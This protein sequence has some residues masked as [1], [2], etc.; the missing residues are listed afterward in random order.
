MRQAGEQYLKRVLTSLISKEAIK[1]YIIQIQ[2][3]EFEIKVANNKTE[4]SKL[5]NKFKELCKAYDRI[6]PQKNFDVPSQNLNYYKKLDEGLTNQIEKPFRDYH[7]ITHHQKTRPSDK[8]TPKNEVDD[9]NAN[10][11]SENNVVNKKP[12]VRKVR[13][14]IYRLCLDY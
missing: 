14:F 5:E 12:I 4:K 3:L 1:K 9:P 8:V 2:A 6:K 10:N 11:T 13:L 7:K